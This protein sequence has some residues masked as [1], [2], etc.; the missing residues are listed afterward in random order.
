[1]PAQQPPADRSRSE[2]GFV[3]VFAIAACLA[4]AAIGATMARSVQSALRQTAVSIE[5]ARAR[6]LADGGIELALAR[7]R[8]A[9]ETGTR[10]CALAGAGTLLITVEDEAGKVSLNSPNEALLRALFLGLGATRDEAD[11]YV[12]AIADYRDTDS[13]S[14]EGGTEAAASRNADFE[15]VSELDRTAGIPAAMRA[16]AKPFLTVATEAPG[17]DPSASPPALLVVLRGE[18]GPAALGAAART[19]PAGFTTPSTRTAYKI[20]AIGMTDGARFVRETT[21][22]RTPGSDTRMRLDGWL[23]G[24]LSA[25]EEAMLMAPAD[26]LPPC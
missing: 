17:V 23:Q 22:V 15:A 3:L 11:H 19:L 10:H 12:A 9:P 13:K 21:A 6:A 2:R 24:E 8:A 7:V 16:R 20:R 14:R 5:I 26:P 4:L 18:D 1:M 25:A